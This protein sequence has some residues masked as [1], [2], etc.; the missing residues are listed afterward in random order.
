ML[1]SL[2]FVKLQNTLA[3]IFHCNQ[4]T[5]KHCCPSKFTWRRMVEL[6]LRLHSLFSGEATCTTPCK[7][8]GEVLGVII[9]FPQSCVPLGVRLQL[10][11]DDLNIIRFANLFDNYYCDTS[12]FKWQCQLCWFFKNNVNCSVNFLKNLLVQYILLLLSTGAMKHLPTAWHL[13][14]SWWIMEM[15]H[16]IF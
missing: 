16:G 14:K 7:R 3:L 5:C 11:N 13:S 15:Y 4:S 6:E 2:L 1:D 12:Y 10:V 8:P 9:A